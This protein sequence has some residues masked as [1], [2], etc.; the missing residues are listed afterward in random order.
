MYFLKNIFEKMDRKKLIS[1]THSIQNL[2][3]W[4]MEI[5]WYADYLSW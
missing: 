5:P 1:F 4:N 2:I 3:A